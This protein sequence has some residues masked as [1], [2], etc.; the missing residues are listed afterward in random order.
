MPLS[1]LGAKAV[2]KAFQK[3]VGQGD[4]GQQ[5]E[6]LVVLFQRGG[7]RFEIDFRLS[8]AGDAVDQRDGRAPFQRRFAQHVGHALLIRRQVRGGVGSIG[9]RDHG[10]WR[11]HHRI[12][13]ALSLQTVNHG[14]GHAGRMRQS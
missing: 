2:L 1:R 14:R 9:R 6:N 3:G 8:G 5:N 10:T 7:N 12:E 4:L 11:Y 13:N